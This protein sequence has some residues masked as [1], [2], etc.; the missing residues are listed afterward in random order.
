MAP[1]PAPA[2]PKLAGSMVMAPA[3]IVST[4]LIRKLYWH[5]ERLQQT[6]VLQK[7]A[8]ISTCCIQKQF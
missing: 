7:N 5:Y 2:P 3:L 1:A 6:M 4:L 8:W